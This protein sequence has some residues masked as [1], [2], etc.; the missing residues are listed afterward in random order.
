MYLNNDRPHI[1]HHFPVMNDKEQHSVVKQHV[2]CALKRKNENKIP[3]KTVEC[4]LK[5]C[6]NWTGMKIVIKEQQ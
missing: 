5:S 3:I 4:T 2:Q 6:K 1:N